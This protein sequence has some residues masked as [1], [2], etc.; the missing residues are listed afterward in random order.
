ML[1][2]RQWLRN[3]RKNE[4]ALIEIEGRVAAMDRTMMVRADED[5]IVEVVGASSAEPADM[6]GLA[7]LGAVCLPRRPPKDLALPGVDFEAPRRD[8]GH[9]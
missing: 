2:V 9:A 8:R 5:K 1:K 7:Q 3:R 6:M 4:G